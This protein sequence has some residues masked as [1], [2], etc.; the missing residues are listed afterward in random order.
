MLN[1]QDMRIAQYANGF[2]T[3]FLLS[4]ILIGCQ[5]SRI[6]VSTL[7][8]T[9]EGAILQVTAQKTKVSL[10]PDST[11]PYPTQVEAKKCTETK[12]TIKRSFIKS[13]KLPGDLYFSIY[14][15]PCY[16]ESDSYP[17]IYL[18][19][20]ITYTDDQWIRLGILDLADA[21][22][23]NGVVAPVIIVL[24]YNPN[25]QRPP[26]SNFGDALV[27]DLI[28]YIDE[29]YATCSDAACRMIGGVSRGGGWA[30]DIFL[31]YP[32]LF[33]AVAGHSPA[34]F[35]RIPSLLAHRLDGLW[36]GQRLWLDVGDTDPE[37]IYLSKVHDAL[38]QSGI[39]HEFHV[40]PGS[41]TE[42]YW[43]SN[44]ADYL[45]WYMGGY[46]SP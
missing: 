15:P 45:M 39:E 5:P 11:L 18:L 8:P 34:L 20:G 44:L 16:A 19:H 43:E 37:L 33:G 42:D 23:S 9:T 38:I 40:Y 3:V 26:D 29:T 17:V 12:G 35:Q 21:Y 32:Q 31:D 27:K 25:P 36:Q 41:H 4:L 13:K 46:S 24:P 1:R 2:A 22:I 14:L 7:V 28:P 10:E 6:P 30:W